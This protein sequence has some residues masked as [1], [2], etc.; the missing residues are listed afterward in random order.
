[1]WCFPLLLFLAP[2]DEFSGNL[3]SLVL[4][5]GPMVL[6]VLL[7]LFF[8][9]VATWAIIVN[10]HRT[11][12]Q[13]EEA[14]AEFLKTFS[15]TADLAS[16][17]DEREIWQTSPMANAFRTAYGPLLS[18]RTGR[19]GTVRLSQFERRV[20]Q[21]GSREIRQLGRFLGFLATTGSVTP[22]I[23]LFG[24]VWGIMKSFQG[25]GL[26]GSASLGAVAPGISEAL[27]ATSAGL[28]A[29]IPAVIAYNHFLNRLQ[30]MSGDFEQ[31]SASLL[32]AA[33]EE[34]SAV[35]SGN[36]V[37]ASGSIG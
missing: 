7:I 4:G 27:V 26:A 1:M 29:A 31:F 28:A 33:E 36:P 35:G 32:N 24:T 5:S 20:A 22:F 30:N 13:A 9:S 25:I 17:L 2:S 21:A 15:E 16:L 19:M 8:F 23:G 14:S 3:L 12:R 11:F 37:P 6:G 10:R 34:E 18:A